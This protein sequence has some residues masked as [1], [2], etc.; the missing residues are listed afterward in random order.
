MVAASALQKYNPIT[1]LGNIHAEDGELLLFQNGDQFVK[2]FA[3]NCVLLPLEKVRF[4]QLKK[5]RH[6]INKLARASYQSTL[7]LLKYVL[8]SRLLWTALSNDL[9]Q[10]DIWA[11]ALN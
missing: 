7:H 4:I 9:L 10:D 3:E 11:R 8:K 5:I 2:L 6:F 1:S